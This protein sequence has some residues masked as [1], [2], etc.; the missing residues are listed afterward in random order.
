MHERRSWIILTS[1][2]GIIFFIAVIGVY[3]VFHKPFDLDILLSIFQAFRDIALGLALIG[4]AGGIGRKILGEQHSN[5]LADRVLQAA[6]GLG[7]LVLTYLV[8]GLLGLFKSWFAW[9]LLLFLILIFHKS[10]KDWFGHLLAIRENLGTLSGFSKL[11][12]MIVSFIVLLRLLEA[13]APPTNFDALVYHL[14]LPSRFLEV[15]KF[16]FTPENPFWGMPLSAELLYTWA[17][18]LGGPETAAVLGWFIGV[19]TLA[20]VVGIGNRIN[21]RAGWVAT[22]A[23]MA[24]E[25]L[26]SSL[27]WAYVDWG[28]ALMACALIIAIDAWGQRRS[29]SLLIAAGLLAGFAFGFKLTAGLVVPAGWAMIAVY[30]NRKELRNALIGF[31][32]AAGFIVFLWLGKN[33]L[34][35][36]SLLY[37]FW[38]TSKWVDVVKSQFF[39]GNIAPWPALRILLMPLSATIEGVE[40]APGFSASIGPL[41]IGLVA[42]IIL[43]RNKANHFI[44]GIGAFVLA[45]WVAWI[46]ATIY[47]T[48]LGQTRLYFSL[49]PAWALLAAAGYEGF[50]NIRISQVR[51]ERLAGVFIVV[52]LLFSG[53]SNL[54]D[55]VRKQPLKVVMGLEEDGVYLTRCLG[56]YYPAMEAV[57]NLSSDSS[58]LTLWEPRGLYCM[59]IC[60][61]DTWIDRWV[62][63]RHRYG[64][65]EQILESWQE[66][67]FTHVLLHRAGMEFIQQNDS[68]YQ[69]AD[70]EVLHNLLKRLSLV[71]SFG[72]GFEL[73]RLAP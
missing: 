17:M 47:S 30:G 55:I 56:A 39:R 12:V 2:I 40:G 26:S 69:M 41:L 22:A 63:D 71:Q 73:Y 36:Q 61:A 18:A 13:L 37:P 72:D 67:G 70:W 31:T 42:G 8:V 43:L 15:G 65:E 14:W 27:A 58:V 3:Y 11:L 29:R 51:F 49:F 50:A 68:R 64:T 44:K 48:Y 53:L 25:T 38:G 24:G 21:P 45:G 66:E 9:C 59:P 33:L 7:L 52:S 54:Q 16:V 32:L 6:F 35:T 4:L 5:P 62:L 20:G 34:F 57:S 1:I 28:T 46:I 60:E 19:L 10:V 23:L